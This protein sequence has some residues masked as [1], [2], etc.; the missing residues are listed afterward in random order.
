[1]FLCALEIGQSSVLKNIGGAT[2]PPASWGPSLTS[3][4][5]H[6]HAHTKPPV[7]DILSLSETTGFYGASSVIVY[8][9]R[10]A[11]RQ[12]LASEHDFMTHLPSKAGV[13]PLWIRFSSPSVCVLGPVPNFFNVLYIKYKMPPARKTIYLQDFY[14]LYSVSYRNREYT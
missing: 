8:A 2:A 4:S 7:Y 5:F 3:C 14:I 9:T 12:T 1:M 13:R 11:A 6:S 10:S